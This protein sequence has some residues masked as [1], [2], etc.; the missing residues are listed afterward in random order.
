[1]FTSSLYYNCQQKLPIDS[2]RY[3]LLTVANH[4]WQ[5]LL[6]E[7]EDGEILGQCV[8]I[9]RRC[10]AH[11]SDLCIATLVF[12]CPCSSCYPVGW[13]RLWNMFRGTQ[14]DAAA[15]NMMFASVDSQ[16]TCCEYAMNMFRG[17][18]VWPRNEPKIVGFQDEHK[19]I[20]CPRMLVRPRRGGSLCQLAFFRKFSNIIFVAAAA[21]VPQ[22]MFHSLYRPFGLC[23][24]VKLIS[25]EYTGTQAEAARVCSSMQK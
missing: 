2:D 6:P 24:T 3:M 19:G 16:Q 10:A 18:A 13:Y 8:A 7:E 9:W 25:R 23:G 21:A 20:P 17:R 22:N 5:Q 12:S 15:K 11:K 4:R 14:P 1:M